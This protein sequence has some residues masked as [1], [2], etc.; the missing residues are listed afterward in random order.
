VVFHEG[1]EKA[2]RIAERYTDYAKIPLA[3]I[4]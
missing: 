3:P 2:A 1:D 4:K